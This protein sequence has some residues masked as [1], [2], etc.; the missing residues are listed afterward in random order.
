MT[1]QK[2]RVLFLGA[3]IILSFGVFWVIGASADDLQQGMILYQSNCLACHGE[4]GDGNGPQAVNFNPPPTDFTSSQMA[5]V[6]DSQI[7]KAIV[8]GVAGVPM[9]SWG[10][11]LQKEDVRT[12]ISAVRSFKK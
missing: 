9:H 11:I 1:T 8:E 6:P 5:S 3:I 10:G 4:K 12:L 7:E 2:K